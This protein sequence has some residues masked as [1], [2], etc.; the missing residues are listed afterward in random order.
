M[1]FSDELLKVRRGGIAP[2][3]PAPPKGLLFP[4]N[5]TASSDIRIVF[6]GSILLSRTAQTVLWKKNYV[7]QNSYYADTW[8]SH[9]D[10]SFHSDTYEFGCHPYPTALSTPVDGSGQNTD[11]TSQGG[12]T[13]YFEIAGLGGHD[14]LASPGGTP[15]LVSKGGWYSHARTVEV[16]GG[17][18]LR[19][20]FY[21]DVDGNP[22]QVIVQD[23]L[24]ADLA[25]AGSTPA[26]YFGCS[27]WRAGQPSAGRNDETPSG[28]L[29]GMAC[30]D[31]AL[32]STHIQNLSDCLDDAAVLAY[33]TANSLTSNLWYLNYNPTPTDI[34]D[35][36][37]NGRH[38]SWANSNRPTAWP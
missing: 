15:V 31:T 2:V 18:T 12:N 29:R 4:S 7:D 1:P 35:K 25:A 9:N 22:S 32:S 27:D 3:P 23:I 34:N 24:L 36:S 16:V 38:P 8:S 10:G 17:T 11:V 6:S 20:S 26:F 37:G 13:H 19:H 33:C 28:I 14:Y 21:V 30:F 5:A